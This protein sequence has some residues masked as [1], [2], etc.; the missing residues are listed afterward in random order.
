MK[1]KIGVRL[2]S[3][4]LRRARMILTDEG[5]SLSEFLI[6]RLQEIVWRRR[7]YARVKKRALAR[8]RNCTGHCW[9][10]PGSRDQLHE[11]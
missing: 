5:I 3:N 11:R 8:L 4:T 2:D 6:A 7:N 9:T 1:T 10:R